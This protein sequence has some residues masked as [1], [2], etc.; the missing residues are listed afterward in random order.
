MIKSYRHLQ[1]FQKVGA[2][3]K[4]SHFLHK[5]RDVTSLECRLR[6]LHWDTGK[7]PGK[8]FSIRPTILERGPFARIHLVKKNFNVCSTA[9]LI[10]LRSI[11]RI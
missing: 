10:Y 8:N 2:S 5:T 6:Q 9:L 4:H 1:G 11:K 3:D 7:I